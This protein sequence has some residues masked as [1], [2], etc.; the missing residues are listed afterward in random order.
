MAKTNKFCDAI[1][2][3]VDEYGF[4]RSDTE[5]KE[6]E[7]MSDMENWLCVHATNYMPRRGKDGKLY[8][9]TTGMATGYKY[10]RATVHMTLNQIVASHMSGNWDAQPI[11]VLMP[12]NDVV[13]KNGEPRMVATEDTFFIPNADTGL[14]LPDSAV[15]VRPNNDTLFNI[16]DKVSTYKTDHFTDEEIETILSFVKPENRSEY[17]KYVNCDFSDKEVQSMLEYQ[18]EIVKETYKKSKDKR[19]FLR[20]LFEETRMVILTKFLREVVVRMTMEKMGYKYIYSHQD[21]ISGAV[22]KT[23]YAKGLEATIDDKGHSTTLESELEDTGNMYLNII[24][25]CETNDIEKIYEFCSFGS[26]GSQLAIMISTDMP[27][28]VYQEYIEVVQR[29]LHSCDNFKNA[30]KLKKGG[31]TAYNPNLDIVLR[32]NAASLSQHYARAMEKLRRNPK[33]PLLKQMLK[34]LS[35]T[36]KRWFKNPVSGKWEPEPEIDKDILSPSNFCVDGKEM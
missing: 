9:P 19:A 5:E 12:Y 18:D 15:I 13:K 3:M 8:I 32:R 2:D 34:D 35:T 21:K 10:P 26:S 29:Y 31:I 23:A 6:A 24:E 17:E 7:Y 28:N 11:V 4:F 16:G 25:I 20:G 27:L 30:D 33:F 36:V 1:K 14:V 22:Y